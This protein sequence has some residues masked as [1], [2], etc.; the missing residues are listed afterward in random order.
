MPLSILL[1][2]SDKNVTTV[3]APFLAPAVTPYTSYDWNYTVIPQAGQNNRTF[4]YPRGRLLGGSSSANY[5]ALQYGSHEN[6]DKVAK[7][8]GDSGWLWSN[9]KRYISKHKRFI[10]TPRLDGHDNYEGEPVSLSSQGIDNRVIETTRQLAEFPYNK[11]TTGINNNLL[12]V[13]WIQSSINNGSRVSSSTSYLSASSGRPNLT[14]LLNAMVT[15]LLPTGSSQ[16]LRTFRNV[17]FADS[18]TN[19]VNESFQV[20]ATREVILSAGS[21]GSVQILQ[22]SGIG[23]P[24]DLKPLGIPVL[25][26]NSE[27]GK[28]L[29]DHPLVPNIFTVQDGASMDHVFRNQ[30]AMGAAIINTF[31]F[32]RLSP[33]LREGLEDPSAGSTTPHYEMIFAN[34]WLSAAAPLPPTGS[35]FTILTSVMT[36]TSRGTIRIHSTNPFDAPLIDP[37]MLTTE[38]DIRVM[39]ESIKSAK[40]FASAS[41]W[42]G[43]ITGSVGPLFSD[44]DAILDD[45]TRQT[46]STIF[47]PTST[48]SMTTF[49]SKNGVTNPDLTVKGTLGLRIVDLS[50]LPFIPSCHP[51]G[52]AYLIAERAADLVKASQAYFLGDEDLKP[53]YIVTNII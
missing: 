41:A 13:G 6:W 48:A 1:A 38:W 46:S 35:F 43:Y 28:N 34:F 26:N 14:I 29:Q 17:Q 25:I 24:E 42:D 7:V 4:P 44:S 32:A 5:M 8:T 21:I 11:D 39:R 36:P 16:G 22:L 52:S 27:V 50:V 12:G 3:N 15:K 18:R 45:Y 47:H 37:N 23:D 40:R 19:S 49:A 30:T 2:F 51:Q 20:Q 53:Q 33:P 9:M 31:G 10:N